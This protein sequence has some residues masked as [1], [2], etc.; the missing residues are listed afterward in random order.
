MRLNPSFQPFWRQRL[1]TLT[2]SAR[3]QCIALCCTRGAGR[4][5][6][7]FRAAALAVACVDATIET[8]AQVSAG[9]VGAFGCARVCDGVEVTRTLPS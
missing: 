1:P 8:E 6:R 2:G 3:E 7:S 4:M 5:C 9:D